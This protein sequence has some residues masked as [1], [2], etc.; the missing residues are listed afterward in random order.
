MVGAHTTHTTQDGASLLSA[1]LNPL[2][3][4]T[5][6]STL[7]SSVSPL[8]LCAGMCVRYEYIIAIVACA[9]GFTYCGV[10]C[11]CSGVERSQHAGIKADVEAAQL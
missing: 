10:G 6:P 3:R 7:R 11:L 9:V 4:H 8:L 5:L 1:S 2:L